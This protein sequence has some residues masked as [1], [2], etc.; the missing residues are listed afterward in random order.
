MPV[1]RTIPDFAAP[2]ALSPLDTT[3][4]TQRE[5]AALLRVS[6]RTL[7]RHR[8]TG[9]GPAF[10]KLGRRVVYRAADLVVFAEAHTH[11]STSEFSA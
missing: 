2:R 10:V 4:L 8:L 9:S 6:E 5:A 7:E 1:T 3:F 11:L